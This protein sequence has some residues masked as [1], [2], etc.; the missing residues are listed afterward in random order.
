MIQAN[1]LHAKTEWQ[2]IFLQSK[3]NGAPYEEQESGVTWPWPEDTYLQRRL[4]HLRTCPSSDTPQE[5]K[6]ASDQNGPRVVDCGG[7]S[8]V[9][10]ATSE[11]QKNPICVEMPADHWSWCANPIERR[12]LPQGFSRRVRDIIGHFSR[13]ATHQTR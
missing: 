13:R 7:W 6:Q 9:F 11:T 1:E 4:N 12:P 2:R 10:W 5:S 8:S 3:V